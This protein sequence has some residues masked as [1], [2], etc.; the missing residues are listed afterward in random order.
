MYLII[1]SIVIVVNLII[2]IT[3]KSILLINLF[4]AFIVFR[5]YLF[6]EIFNHQK[7]LTNLNLVKI[8]FYFLIC[9][10]IILIIMQILIIHHVIIVIIIQLWQP[11]YHV[12]I[13]TFN[14]FYFI[15]YHFMIKLIHIFKFIHL[16][17]CFNFLTLK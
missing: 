16:I 4:L 14:L 11:I 6:W 10:I 2:K 9:L 8:N 13:F 7:F 1:I 12:I 17:N 3:K 5:F 15:L